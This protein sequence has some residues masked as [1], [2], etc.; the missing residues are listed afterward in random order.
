M[1]DGSLCIEGVR[2]M[3][4]PTHV[5]ARLSSAGAGMPYVYHGRLR[6]ASASTSAAE[7]L[8]HEGSD[9]GGSGGA[10]SSAADEL[11]RLRPLVGQRSAARQAG[12]GGGARS[13]KL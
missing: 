6:A 1:E 12:G 8:L 5:H 9:V 7:A 3:C 13:L 10:R 4:R 2:G 11:S